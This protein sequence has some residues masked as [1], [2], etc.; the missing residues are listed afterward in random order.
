IIAASVELN[1][2]RQRLSSGEIM[3]V[4]QFDGVSFK[5]IRTP[6]YKGNGAGRMIN[7]LAYTFRV[8]MPGAT[9]GLDKPSAVIGSSVHPFAGVAGAILAKRYGVPFV[10]E[11]RDLWPQTLVDLGRLSEKS[12]TTRVLRYLEKWLYKRADRIVTLLP[13]AADYIVPLG[14]SSKKIVWIPNGVE[15]DGYP[16]PKQPTE[17]DTFTLMY[18]GAHGQANGLSN[19]L[20]AMA[21]LQNRTGMQHVRLRMIGD[22]PMKP[23]LIQMARNLALKNVEFENPVPKQKIPALAKEADVFVIVVRDMKQLYRYGISMNKLFDYLAAGRPTIIAS[24]AS[25]N[26]IKEA[27]AGITVPSEN[28]R[29]LADAIATLVTMSQ[30]ERAAMG[31]AGRTYVEKYNSYE[32]LAARFATMLNECS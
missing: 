26:P 25:N 14:I 8:L 31:H 32:V 29:A 6:Q 15:L 1:T 11:V 12:I 24:E 10:F 28:P 30:A 23:E 19:V 18:F 17:T 13:H 22:G 5:W 3:R 2:G 7:I 27:K 9:K 20:N 16:V 4:D 21:E